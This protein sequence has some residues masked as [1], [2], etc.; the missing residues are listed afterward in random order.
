MARY[1]WG[2]Y[3]DEHGKGMPV[4]MFG[5]RAVFQER[6]PQQVAEK[7]LQQLLV[8]MCAS[9]GLALLFDAPDLQGD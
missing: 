6:L 8:E 7:E 5:A 3:L 9:R 1:A 4:S 2:H